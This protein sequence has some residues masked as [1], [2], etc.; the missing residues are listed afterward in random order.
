MVSTQFVPVPPQGAPLH[1]VKLT[2]G[3]GCAVRVTTVPLANDA[4]HVP[5]V[6][7]GPPSP[8]ATVQLMLPGEEVTFPLPMIPEMLPRTV[9]VNCA[10]AADTAVTSAARK[11]SAASLE[12][13]RRRWRN[14]GEELPTATIPEESQKRDLL[15]RCSDNEQRRGASEPAPRCDS[16]SDRIRRSGGLMF[17]LA[18]VPASGRNDPVEAPA[19]RRYGNPPDLCRRLRDVRT[20]TPVPPNECVAGFPDGSPPRC[21]Q[22]LDGLG[23]GFSAWEPY[24]SLVCDRSPRILPAHRRPGADRR[25][26]VELIA[27]FG[28]A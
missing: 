26:R 1:D 4:R 23:R 28:R 18:G 13:T 22:I 2:F 7:G 24:H 17:T 12:P 9:I 15:Q 14:A 25:C 3:S 5:V 11:Q 16:P 27:A 20:L 8:S 21:L 10:S 19:A 6:V